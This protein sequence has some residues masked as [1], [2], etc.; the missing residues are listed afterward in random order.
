MS[1]GS[2]ANDNGYLVLD[3]KDRENFYQK[4]QIV[5]IH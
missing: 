5:K 3:I 2:M 1:Y 4:M